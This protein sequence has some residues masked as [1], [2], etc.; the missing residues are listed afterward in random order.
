MNSLYRS[1]LKFLLFNIRAL[2]R[3]LFS[4]TKICKITNARCSKDFGT[5]TINID[6]SMWGVD[7]IFPEA[8]NSENHFEH[9]IFFGDFIQDIQRSKHIKKIYTMSPFREKIIND[10]IGKECVVVGSFIN[11]VNKY[12]FE[13]KINEDSVLFFP[14]H[15]TLTLRSDENFKKIKS[16]ISNK[17]PLSK[18][19][20]SLFYLDFLSEKVK[21]EV[22]LNGMIPFSFGSR[23]DP[24]F[25]ARFK[26]FVSQFKN[27]YTNDIG[28]HVGY[29]L[30]LE[31]KIR[32]VDIENKMLIASNNRFNKELSGYKNFELVEK[33][34]HEVKRILN[35]D[36]D[37]I[38]LSD[39]SILNEYF[40]H[41]I[42]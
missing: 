15:T 21:K 32:Y 8:K 23:Y 3:N 42:K 20:I 16:F 18:I 27:V 33:Q 12:G 2:V 17:H 1:I 11:H 13:E 26:G 31:K 36:K 14:A 6:N 30:A 25:L 40:G 10:R 22:E 34:K 4:C 41:K 39:E 9:G 28:T 38:H 35:F 29:C 7:K 24:M 19:Y 37:T 5:R